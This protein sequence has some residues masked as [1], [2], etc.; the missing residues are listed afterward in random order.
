MQQVDAN[1]S[2]GLPI[3]QALLNVEIELDRIKRFRNLHLQSSAI[4][5]LGYF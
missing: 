5:K 4:R 1:K 3:T 2:Y